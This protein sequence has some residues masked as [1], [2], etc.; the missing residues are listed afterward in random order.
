MGLVMVWLDK[1][2]VAHI[3]KFVHT[4]YNMCSSVW[5]VMLGSDLLAYLEVSN[6]AVSNDAYLKAS[7]QVVVDHFLSISP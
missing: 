1:M 3:V 6:G 4:L 7:K 5:W 2:A